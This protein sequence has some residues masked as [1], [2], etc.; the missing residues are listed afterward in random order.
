MYKTITIL[1]VLIFMATKPVNAQTAIKVSGAM[2]NVMQKGELFRTIAL[3][4]VSKSHLYGLG[5]LEYLTGEL[6]ILDGTIYS[7][8]VG[9]GKQMKVA[10]SPKAR[11]PF[12]V[13]THVPRWIEHN[14]PD[15]IQNMQQLEAYLHTRRGKSGPFPF[16][17]SGNFPEA[18]IHVVNL[19]KGTVVRSPRDAHQGQKDYVLYNVTAEIL[20]FFSTEHKAV[21]THHDT[22]LHL[23]LITKDKTSMGHLDDVKFA[24]G[25]KI[26]LPERLN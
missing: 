2:R 24:K 5:P 23:H 4:T 9:S 14:L 22:F 20:G 21:F 15:S 16:K 6:L 1:A 26:Y 17:I 19:P 18:R 12:L 25:T 8:T 13:Y 10:V 3:D 11:A 7:S